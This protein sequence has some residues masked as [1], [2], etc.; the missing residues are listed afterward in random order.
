M[1][2]D[3][4]V[5]AAALKHG[6]PEAQI[7][8]DWV[9]SHLLH[10]LAQIQD[11]TGFV[12]YG[13][14]ALCR[15]WCPDLRL[16]EDIDLM[17]HDFPDA[18]PVMQAELKRAKRREFPDL[19]WSPAD[20]WQRTLTSIATTGQRVVKMQFVEPR[21]R[22]DRIPT[23]RASVALRYSDLPE[24]VTLTVPSAEGFAAMK[25]MAWHQRQE[26]RDLYDLAAL[27]EVGAITAEA[28][29]LTTEVSSTRLGVRALHHDLPTSVTQRWSE[30]LAHQMGSVLSAEQC[31][32]HV[33]EALRSADG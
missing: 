7:W 3:S 29:D 26:P 11:T 18:V 21:V 5:R 15:T 9:V 20:M 25:L 30:Q 1:I 22:E 28:I 10:G 8:R 4:E 31:L 16:S 32:E 23:V 13:G 12:F 6:V 14:T 17:V 27:A 33:L 19:D 2:S 24:S